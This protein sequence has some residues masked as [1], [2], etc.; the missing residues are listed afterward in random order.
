M[1]VRDLQEALGF[2]TPQSIYKWQWGQCLPDYDKL[3]YLSDL[4]NVAVE[5]ILVRKH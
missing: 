4:W 2:T 1:S 5:E 3:L